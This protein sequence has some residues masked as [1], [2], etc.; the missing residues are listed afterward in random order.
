[1]KIAIISHYDN[2]GGAGKAAWRLFR[3]FGKDG[4]EVRMFVF[5]KTASDPNVRE[6]RPFLWRMKHYMLTK[7][8]H[9]IYKPRQMFS[10]LLVGN[11]PLVRAVNAFS[12][13]I[14][15]LHWLGKYVL[16]PGDFSRLKAPVCWSL[17]DLNAVTGGCHYSGS[18]TGFQSGCGNCPALGSESE[19]DIS[20]RQLKIKEKA[21][22]GK[23]ITFIGS[24]LWITELAA[25]STVGKLHKPVNL[26]TFADLSVFRPA[27]RP[28][29]KKSKLQLIFSAASGTKEHRK[30]FDLLA[31][32]LTYLDPEEIALKIV[33][34]ALPPE[35]NESD[36]QIEQLQPTD[37]DD[38]LA[39]YYQQADMAVVPSREENLSNVIM[40]ALAC[41]LPVAAFRIG[42]NADLIIHQHNGYLAETVDARAL[43]GGIR[44]MADNLERGRL[45]ENARKSMESRFSPE[46]VS[47]RYINLFS[48]IL[49]GQSNGDG[50]LQHNK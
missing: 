1:M 43:S 17:H 44:W 39:S 13:D 18:C 14:I 2:R 50:T 42:G 35:L 45:S 40:E 34:D 46:A 16:G 27:E 12:P 10:Y 36:F 30:G 6:I 41:G 47:K 33:C 48:E 21:Y 31:S 20:A 5:H 28:Y 26:P 11:R 22:S 25:K 15:H 49:S 3:Q 29:T 37:D 19:R 23:Q 32:A 38:V 8:I 4:H 24:S 9:R 7:L